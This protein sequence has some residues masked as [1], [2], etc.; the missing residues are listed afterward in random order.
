M[1]PQ[2]H[3][4]FNMKEPTTGKT[5]MADPANDKSGERP[6]LKEAYYLDNFHA[7]L[8]YVSGHYA[9]LLREYEKDLIMQF[10]QLSVDAQRLFVRL[11][12]RMGPVF[13]KDRIH[14]REIA[15]LDR[16]IAELQCQH[17]MV[18]NPEGYDDSCLSVLTRKEIHMLMD[19]LKD[20]EGR[21]SFFKKGKQELIL[22][23]LEAQSIR[24]TE[25]IHGKYTFL[26]PLHTET[27]AIL[28]LLFFGNTR[29]NLSDFILEDIGV[30][31][32]EPYL[33]REED[34]LF[35]DRSVV[36]GY[37]FIEAIKSRLWQAMEEADSEGVVEIGEELQHTPMP[38]SLTR[39]RERRYLEIG[40]F[41]EK[42]KQWTEALHYYQLTTIPP[43][44]ERKV[45]IL[46]RM[47]K[48]RETLVILDSMINEPVNGEE[49]DFAMIFREKTRKKLGMDYANIT[50]KRISEEII[51]MDPIPG[52][53]V[54]EMA[55]QYFRKQGITGFYTEN[56]LWSALFGLACWDIIFMSLPGVFFH[57]FQRGPVDLFSDEFRE[58]RKEA[59]DERM[60]EIRH[61]RGWKAK[62]LGRFDE[63]KG[64][65]N[66]LVSWKKVNRHDLEMALEWI[67]MA[68]LADILDRMARSLPDFRAGFPDLVVFY[69][70]PG[71][72]R[73]LEIKGP[74]DQ[75]RSNQKRWL[76]YF[77]DKGIPAGV[78]RLSFPAS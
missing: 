1:L 33:I 6:V 5:T 24:I 16:C 22:S 36:D 62:I 52:S 25:I 68:H 70:G 75:L 47:G 57:P 30:L 65:A 11:I 59:L 31:K 14:Y 29:Q 19:D 37:L 56:N 64:T 77:E 78:I 54:E 8:D 43:S 3:L 55:L 18:V 73:L 48:S 51:R 53:K 60:E 42:Q 10:R 69:P 61:K 26:V 4:T 67:P 72:Y 49:L 66:A 27:I 28:F 35:T 34:R 76:S 2:S 45:R 12:T 74:G 23:L 32:Y 44:R 46:D 38:D 58:N 7:L 15:D 20:L 40:R 39:R 21:E 17:F 41:L 13:R 63:K 71:N 9:D 50:R